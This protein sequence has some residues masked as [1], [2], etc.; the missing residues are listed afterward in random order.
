[1]QIADV[2][3]K[4]T[5]ANKTDS[6]Q[7]IIQNG[8]QP[9]TP[10][11][12]QD[13][14]AALLQWVQQLIQ[15]YS[16]RINDF[17]RSWRDGLAFCAILHRYCSQSG[18]K[19]GSG[20]FDFDSVQRYYS[21]TERLR[22]A[23]QLAE[24]RFG[25]VPLLDASDVDTAIPDAR[26][27]MTY[28]SSLYDALVWQ[29]RGTDERDMRAAD[30]SRKHIM[31]EYLAQ[32]S[33]L[34]QWMQTTVAQLGLNDVFVMTD[35]S[36]QGVDN[37]QYAVQLEACRECKRADVAVRN[38]QRNGLHELWRQLEQS[39]S[40]NVSQ[41][42]LSKTRVN[43]HDPSGGDKNES[44]Q[45]MC[46]EDLVTPN[47][48]PPHIDEMWQKF[49]NILSEKE[50]KLSAWWSLKQADEEFGDELLLQKASSAIRHRRK[51]SS[52]NVI[53]RIPELDNDDDDKLRSDFDD[54]IVGKKL[55][56]AQATENLYEQSLKDLISK[57][58]VDSLAINNGNNNTKKST[59]T[60]PLKSTLQQQPNVSN[61]EIF[62]AHTTT[63][64]SDRQLSRNNFFGLTNGHSA[65]SDVWAAENQAN[66]LL[67]QSPPKTNLEPSSVNAQVF[68]NSSSA[69]NRN[70]ANEGR[71][72]RQATT[73]AL[74]SPPSPT[75]QQP[76]NTHIT[77]RQ[78]KVRIDE[79]S[80]ALSD[81]RLHLNHTDDE[82]QLSAVKAKSSPEYR[83]QPRTNGRSSS[84]ARTVQVPIEHLHS[85]GDK[86]ASGSSS[87]SFHTPPQP[88][89]SQRPKHFALR[90]TSSAATNRAA[91]PNSGRID[92]IPTTF[93][94]AI[95]QQ[96]YDPTTST[97]FCYDTNNKTSENKPRTTIRPIKF[98]EAIEFGIIDPTGLIVQDPSTQA[99]LTLEKG[100]K[101]N[102]VDRTHGSMVSN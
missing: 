18:G 60:L 92:K 20:G 47:L 30:K 13:A 61:D 74:M 78:P 56:S 68:T 55:P 70:S 86:V 15:D 100:L 29:A 62:H 32:A 45:I 59:L 69:L 71:P 6:Q 77:A 93:A 31:A 96:L 87:T 81:M 85:S 28:V 97:L 48:T 44:R 42:A 102:V 1:M 7:Q 83:S 95:A 51:S 23:F 50:R 12:P 17:S 9:P 64:K 79:L 24:H 37:K 8:K 25:V 40:G 54:W 66:S 33:A 63:N 2:A 11:T 43:L 75:D 10:I 38:A 58:R 49:L 82:K 73:S 34:L 36:S 99:I 53:A 39:M 94:R 72:T 21:N 76:N 16:V 52:A 14:K 26:S 3:Y 101:T 27:I 80:Q 22:F 90:S 84:R 67:I 57:T 19:E 91:M 65:V 88:P 89:T 41:R 4:T 98:E 46:A 35:S 5:L